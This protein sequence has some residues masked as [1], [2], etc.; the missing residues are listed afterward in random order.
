MEYEEI[1]FEYK[2]LDPKPSADSFDFRATADETPPADWMP[3]WEDHTEMRAD[4]G[5]GDEMP[6]DLPA[7]LVIMPDFDFA[8]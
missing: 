8:F 1:K 6:E 7:G 4:S 2:K 5:L 3:A